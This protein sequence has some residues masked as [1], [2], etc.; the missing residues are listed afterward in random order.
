MESAGGVIDGGA[1]RGAGSRPGPSA[2]VGPPLRAGG[3][4]ARVWSSTTAPGGGREAPARERDYFSQELTLALFFAT[5]AAAALSLSM[6]FPEMRL[7]TKFWSAD[8]H[9]NFL[10]TLSAG[11]PLFAKSLETNLSSVGYPAYPH[12]WFPFAFSSS[13]Q[14]LNRFGSWTRYRS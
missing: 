8:V 10:T 5:Q 2:G 6:C 13:M 11:D 1:R 7:D 3:W 12:P 14:P 9:L 4:R